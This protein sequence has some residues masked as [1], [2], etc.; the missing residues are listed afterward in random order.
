MRV[1]RIGFACSAVCGL[2]DSLIL[3]LLFPGLYGHISAVRRWNAQAR[4]VFD[5]LPAG[6][7]RSVG[8]MGFW[9]RYGIGVCDLCH[10]P[11]SVRALMIAFR[12]LHELLCGMCACVRFQLLPYW[13]LS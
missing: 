11:S 9:F 13:P 1:A 12:L 10:L 2:P 6:V 3:F 4:E 5:G 7:W 8:S